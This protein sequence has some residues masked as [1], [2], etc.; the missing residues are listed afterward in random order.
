MKRT[1]WQS[2][3]E[4]RDVGLSI[5]AIS[6]RLGVHRRTV[7]CALQHKQPP[8]HSS[9]ARGSKIDS[10]RGW[11]LAKLEQFPQLTAVRLHQM[12]RERGCDGSYSLVKQCVAQLRPRLKPVYLTLQFEPGECAQVDWGV[13]QSIDVKGGRRR[14]SF[15]TMVLCHSRMLYVE[16]SLGEAT[17]H[18][19]Q[20][21]HNAFAFYGGVP[22][23]VMVDNCKTAVIKAK[24]PGQTPQINPA[25][26]QFADHYGF[27][28]T[29]CNAG[30][31]N[32]KGRV[33]NAVGYT[34]K[35]FLAGRSPS[36]L[37][38]M[39]LAVRDWLANIAN[40]R[41]HGTIKR[42]PQDVFTLEERPLLGPMPSSG[43]PC[44]VVC[45][46]VANNRCRVTVDTNRYSVPPQYGST[47][48]ILHKYADRIVLY[49][50][51]GQFV[52]DH[53]R[54]YDRNQDIVSQEHEKQL[55]NV[56]RYR[57]DQHAIE[58]FL[59]LGSGAEQ[60][61][62]GLREKR[63]DYRSQVRKINALVDIHGRDEVARVILDALE[64]QAFASDYLLTI[65]EARRRTDPLPG[66]LHV[67]RRQ[68]MLELD[69]PEPD[70][71]LYEDKQNDEEN[72]K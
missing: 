54:S 25:Y 35:S 3:H 52:A 18:W 56:T 23:R 43:H 68:D 7:R 31:P 71:D 19:L 67:T 70:L 42:R 72:D 59:T 16:M 39:N 47:R 60:Y 51:D 41:V 14:I 11:L 44:S 12:L 45:C 65:L 27:T 46:C 57:R 6:R 33:E 28:I 30:R 66:P 1:L 64:H 9:K 55:K 26:Q 13:W 50:P 24:T 69:I 36:S 32:E 8:R 5:R 49:A 61:L 40:V 48:L 58:T 2:I 22:Q 62:A 21:H 37:E 17:E 10:H 4:L 34:K 15:F 29:P 63:P 53:V 20:A 38:A